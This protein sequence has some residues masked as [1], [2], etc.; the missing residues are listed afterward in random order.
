MTYL[1]HKYGANYMQHSCGAIRSI[2]PELI[3]CGVDLLDL[4]Q[5]VDGMEP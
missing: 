3:D 4:I 1:A 5:K 2:I